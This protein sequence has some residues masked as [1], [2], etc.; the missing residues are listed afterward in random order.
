MWFVDDT[1][2]KLSE[3]RIAARQIANGSKHVL[4]SIQYGMTIDEL[5]LPICL[6]LWNILP[7]PVQ[8]QAMLVYHPLPTTASAYRRA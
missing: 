4:S 8:D 6:Q 5:N 1:L 7:G 2:C 3:P